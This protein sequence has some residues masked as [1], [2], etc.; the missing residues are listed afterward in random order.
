MNNNDVIRAYDEDR[1]RWTAWEGLEVEGRLCGVPSL[2][3][4]DLAKINV[5]DIP[6]VHIFVCNVAINPDYDWET[7]IDKALSLGKLITIECEIDKVSLV[8]DHILNR[9]VVMA[10]INNISANDILR[11]K[12]QDMIRLGRYECLVFNAGCGQGPKLARYKEDVE[13]Q[14]EE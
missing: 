4:T 3:V 9:V 5:E 12:P 10:C 14:P 1:D 8:P 7:W 2:F 13:W 11:L 6:H